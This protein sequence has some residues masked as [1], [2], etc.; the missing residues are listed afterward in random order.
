MPNEPG[1]AIASQEEYRRAAAALRER[2]ATEPSIAALAREL[3]R[4]LRFEI[5]HGV[6]ESDR[7]LPPVRP[8]RAWRRTAF[9]SDIHG[10]LGGL[11]AVLDDI[12]RQDCDRIVCLGDLVEGGPENDRVVQTLA[13]MGIACVRG[14]H[15]ENNDVALSAATRAYLAALPE[16]IAEDDVLFTHISP[17]PIKRKIDHAVEAWNVFDESA[18]RLIFIGHVHVPYIFGRRSDAYGEST[19]HMFEYNRP[20]ALARDDAYIV[21]VGSVAYG[22][23]KVGRVRYAIWDTQAATIELRA[24]DGPLLSLDYTFL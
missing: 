21:S 19:R 17:R 16:Q 24:I 5:A 14:N 15:D 10:S 7:L 12:T 18:F 1:N 13:D 22:R 23:D 3:E 6:A 2:L 9:I 20:F 8:G 11:D 4:L